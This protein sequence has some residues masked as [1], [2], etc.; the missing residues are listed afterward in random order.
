MSTIDATAKPASR[1]QAEAMPAGDAGEFILVGIPDVNGSIRGK[2]LRPA[3]FES[4]V[5]DGTVMTDLLLALDPT[6]TPISDYTKFGIRSGAGDLLIRPE[7]TTLHDLTWRPGWKICLATPSWPD[8]SPCEIASREVLRRVLGGLSEL[9]Y[10]AVAAVEYELRLLDADGKPLSSGLSY[11]LGELGGFDAF[12]RKL[13]PAL[14]ALGVELSAVHTEAGPGLLELN[15]GARP[16]LRA[17]DDAALTKMAVK[18]LAATM[19]LRASFLAKTAPG[20]EGSSGHI[21]LSCWSDGANAFRASDAK[22]LPAVFR[23]AIAGVLEHLPAASLLLNPTINSYKRLVPGWFAPVN[24]SWGVENRSCAV[25]AIVRK[26]H[27]ELCRLEC[28]RPGADANPYL[29]LAAVVASAADGM[30]RQLSPP[31]AIEGDAYSR[32]ELPELPGSLESAIQAFEADPVLRQALDQ[33][34]SDY[35]VTSR[36]WEVKAFRATVTDWER[37]RYMR[38]V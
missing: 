38:T 26:D 30:K 22:G 6:D 27:P 2:A 18:D 33:R 15:L 14:E 5:R 7:V 3:A 8:G 36:A 17:A 34:F 4:A 24:A 13:A 35:Y 19:G 16:A 21:H 31:A 37:D 10:E 12:V 25:R 32:E 1:M 11:S 29:A 28:R 9:G 20:E 23:S